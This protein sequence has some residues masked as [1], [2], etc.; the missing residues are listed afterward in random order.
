M[1]IA[2]QPATFTGTDD[3]YLTQLADE[4]ESALALVAAHVLTPGSVVVDLG[5]NIGVTTTVM[6]RHVPGCRLVAVEAGPS[7]V[8]EL[9]TNLTSNGLDAVEVVHAA[10][11]DHD[12]R[13]RFH[14][15]S[16]FGHVTDDPEAHDVDALTLASLAQRC[17]LDQLD[18]VKIDV[19]GFEPQVIAGMGDLL[20]RW[21]PIV[22]MELN[23]WTLLMRGH[24]P[25][26]STAEIVSH[27]SAVYRVRRADGP[28][29]ERVGDDSTNALDIARTLI[30]DNIVHHRSWED[31]VL[32]PHGASF[33]A[34][35]LPDLAR[36]TTPR[37][38]ETAHMAQQ[39][40]AMESSYSWRVT[41]PLRAGARWWNQRRT[42]GSGRPRRGI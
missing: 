36:T 16:A 41:A 5:A 23:T 3:G 24:D 19:E 17:G 20:S 29:V 25:I 6:A 31:L 1:S 38:G 42:T 8:E 11:G 21:S 4:P 39:L 14:E 18:F 12:G 26:A 35:G 22:W 40:A 15:A 28:L 9:R 30:H 33:D 2:G 34:D 37:S 7:M 32:V 10:V 13:V 27:F